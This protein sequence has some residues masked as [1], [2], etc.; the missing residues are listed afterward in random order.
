MTSLK[1]KEWLNRLSKIDYA[2]QPIVNTSNGECYGVEALLRNIKS[3]GFSSINALFDLAYENKVLHQVDLILRRKAIQ[4]FASLRRM[5]REKLFFNVDRRVLDSSDYQQ[6]TTANM[7]R[8]FGLT[9][10]TICFEI[11]EK[12]EL[13][14]PKE[15][16]KVLD[17]YR[18]QKFKIAMDD[19]G[20]GFSGLHMLYYAEP[21][22]IKID[23][24]FIQD[25]ENDSK[26]RLFVSSIVDVAHHIG[27]IVIAEGVETKKEFIICQEIGCDLV[28]GYFIQ[29][30]EQKTHLLKS[31]YRN[32]QVLGR[33]ERKNAKL[34]DI[35]LIRSEMKRIETIPYDMNVYEAFEKFKQNKE[36]TFF[37]VIN[38]SH[39]PIGIVREKSFKDYAYSRFG[40]ELL[41]NPAFGQHLSKFVTKYPIADIHHPLEKIIHTYSQNENIEGILMVDK[42]KYIGFLSAPSLL[43]VLNEK[44]ITEARDQNPISKLPGNTMVTEYKNTALE[45]MKTPYVFVFFFFDNFKPYNDKYGY[46]QGDR[47]ILIFSKL[48]QKTIKGSNHFI[49]HMGV[50]DFFA[51]FERETPEKVSRDISLTIK[52]FH[53]HGIKMYDSTTLNRGYIISKNQEGKLNKYPLIDVGA[54]ILTLPENRNRVFT[55]GEIANFVEQL[56]IKALES[57]EKIHTASILDIKPAT[58]TKNATISREFNLPRQVHAS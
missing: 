54:V 44:N 11:S 42:M 26:K 38:E 19:Y 21:D 13:L 27:S 40:A 15:I 55:G 18:N 46:R 7:L 2:F 33:T 1:D 20:I 58:L 14:N 34:S 3:A 10:D 49:G 31:Q 51:G 56:K 24:F 29:H 41:Q 45:N 22:F 25:I 39:E 36:Y 9:Q 50:Y 16:V 57:P 53:K 17:A 28:Q 5:N 12:K 8:E 4:K 37:P 52:Q 35:N 32:I 43:K 30:P 23:R 6:G 48:L 47:V